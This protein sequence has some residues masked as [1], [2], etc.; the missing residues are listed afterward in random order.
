MNMKTITKTINS[1]FEVRELTQ[2]TIRSSF[3]IESKKKIKQKISRIV[4][5][6]CK[7]TKCIH[8]FVIAVL[9]YFDRLGSDFF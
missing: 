3:V 7:I 2:K 9:H 5:E 6:L 4:L 8:H 1:S